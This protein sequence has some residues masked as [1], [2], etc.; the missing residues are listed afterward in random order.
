[1]WAELEQ[2]CN[3]IDEL[4]RFLRIAP[5]L[6]GAPVLWKSAVR[7]ARALAIVCSVA[8]FESLMASCVVAINARINVS[9][10]SIADLNRPLRSLAAHSD[11]V[12]IGT[13]ARSDRLWPKRQRLTSLEICTD[14]VDLRTRREG[15]EPLPPF[16]GSTLRI[17]DI[18]RVFEVYGVSPVNFNLSP[19]AS[20]LRKLA[21][22][23]NDIAHANIPFAQV[24]SRK[25]FTVGEV[26][27]DLDALEGIAFSIVEALHCYLENEDF[28]I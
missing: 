7:E 15:H 26:E 8:E 5:A 3:R 10:L 6:E 24:F 21:D 13:L 14:V 11:F 28:R 2:F 12:S 27:K 16:D 23:R 22:T 4:R 17:E 9:Q 19:G 20:A 18:Q 25:G 1:M